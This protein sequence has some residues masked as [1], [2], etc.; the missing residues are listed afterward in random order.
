MGGERFD[1]LDKRDFLEKLLGWAEGSGEQSSQ[2]QQRM[3]I[4]AVLL[5][6]RWEFF[7]GWDWLSW[8]E[9]YN[10]F[11]ACIQAGRLLGMKRSKLKIPRTCF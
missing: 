9:N 11:T 1:F 8:E 10:G 2:H 4:L 5:H 7:I 3:C 6:R